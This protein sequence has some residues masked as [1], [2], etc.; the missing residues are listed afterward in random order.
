MVRPRPRTEEAAIEALVVTFE[1]DATVE[2]FTAAN[3]DDV[4]AFADVGGLLA[5]I[6]IVEPAT[7]TYGGIK[8]FR[9]FGGGGEAPRTR[10]LQEHRRRSDGRRRNLPP[11]PGNRSADDETQPRIDVTGAIRA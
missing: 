5:K 9:D 6:W 11:V 2:E 1:T 3:E 4:L 8:L 7:N 10:R